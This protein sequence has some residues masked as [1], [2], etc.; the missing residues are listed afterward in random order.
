LVDTISIR[1]ENAFK[2]R[3]QPKRTEVL[4][5]QGYLYIDTDTYAVL[6]ATLKSTQKINVNFINGISTNWNMIIPT[7]IHF[8][9]KICNGNRND[10]FFKKE[11]SKSIIAKRSVDYSEYQFN[12]P[13]ED[14][15][16]KRK[17][18]EYD[19]KFVEKDD[20]YW[21]KARPDSLSK[22]NRI[23]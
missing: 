10:S 4:A 11:T 13:L 5:F 9:Q 18:E 2:I 21:V 12:K 22:S 19:D 23:Y 1:G 3:Y 7:K 17:E 20:A 8:T 6:G 14:K 16:F 15:V